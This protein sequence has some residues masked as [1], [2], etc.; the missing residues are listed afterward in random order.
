MTIFVWIINVKGSY[1][2]RMHYPFV[3]TR[4]NK[5]TFISVSYVANIKLN[6]EDLAQREDSWASF[7]TNSIKLVDTNANLYRLHSVCGET[8]MAA[9]VNV[10]RRYP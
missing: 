4:P 6:G 5:R 1:I 3:A 8:G 2:E 10:I 9:A 7:D